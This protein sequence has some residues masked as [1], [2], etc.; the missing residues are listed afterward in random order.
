MIKLFKIFI[1]LEGI[2]MLH[3]NLGI[4]EHGHLTF[5]GQDTIKLANEYKT[6]LYLIDEETIRKNC[7]TYVNALKKYFGENSIPLV[8]TILARREQAAD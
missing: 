4:N 8:L 7:K 2:F 1:I 3:S 6:P 5:A